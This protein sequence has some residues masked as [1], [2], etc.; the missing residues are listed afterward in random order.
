MMDDAAGSVL[1]ASALLAYLQAEPGGQTVQAALAVGGIMSIVNYAEVLSRL[2]DVGEEPATAHRRLQE[3]GLIG[4]LLKLVALTEDDAV[5]IARLRIAT[6]AQGLS[7]GDRAC[8]ATARRL[9]RSV[10]TADRSWAAVDV[11][12]TVRLIRP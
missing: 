10:V 4:G 5:A 8:L 9:G 2:S 11:G 3:H 6:R 12:V 1:D 7:L